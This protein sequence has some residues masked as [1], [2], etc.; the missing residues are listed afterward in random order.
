MPT[1]SAPLRHARYNSGNRCTARPTR[2]IAAR[3]SPQPARKYPFTWDFVHPPVPIAVPRAPPSGRSISIAATERFGPRARVEDAR[4]N[5]MQPTSIAPRTGPMHTPDRIAQPCG[6]SGRDALDRT[7]R[8]VFPTHTR[9]S[10][11]SHGRVQRGPAF[12]CEPPDYSDRTG[13]GYRRTVDRYANPP[14]SERRSYPAMDLADL[15]EDDP[16]WTR[17][18]RRQAVRRRLPRW[19]SAR[20]QPVVDPAQHVVT[21]QSRIRLCGDS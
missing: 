7:G 10:F 1:Y 6:D 19:S 16:G 18:A 14:D 3:S 4:I 17:P 20:Y 21:T 9:N 11:R 12:F 5:V 2:P 8:M 15:V 13:P